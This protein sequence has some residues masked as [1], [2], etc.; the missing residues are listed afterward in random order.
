MIRLVSVS[1]LL[2]LAALAATACNPP[3][4]SVAPLPPP[5]VRAE[6]STPPPGVVRYCWEEPM[7]DIRDTG[8]GLDEEGHWYRPYHKEVREARQGRWRPCNPGE[9]GSG[10]TGNN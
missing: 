3:R 5:F 7:V 2:V 8:P 1:Q 9:I 4:S 10:E 6:A